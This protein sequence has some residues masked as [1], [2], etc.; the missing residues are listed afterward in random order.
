VELNAL[1]VVSL[2][3]S[4]RRSVASASTYAA[5]QAVPVLEVVSPA[6]GEGAV[7]QS[8]YRA[9]DGGVVDREVGEGVV[10]RNVVTSEGKR[11]Y[12]G[13]AERVLRR[14]AIS[15]ANRIEHTE[16]ARAAVISAR[17]LLPGGLLSSKEGSGF[18]CEGLRQHHF[19]AKR[20]FAL[21][22]GSWEVGRRTLGDSRGL[23]MVARALE[24][25]IL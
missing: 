16:A 5:L 2:E 10:A 7:G 24:P 25:G 3:E 9:G 18:L 11:D 8:G 1:R 23:K 12:L 15:R 20:K 17:R 6:L 22:S 21:L 19:R 13:R 4:L 14:A